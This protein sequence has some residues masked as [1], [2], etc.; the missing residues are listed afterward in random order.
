MEIGIIGSGGVGQALAKDLTALEHQ[1]TIGTH[2]P[3]K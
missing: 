2:S 3:E 1:V